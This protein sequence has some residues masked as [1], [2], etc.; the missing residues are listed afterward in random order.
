[1]G[2]AGK[3]NANNTVLKTYLFAVG[4]LGFVSWALQGQIWTENIVRIYT[5]IISETK[6]DRNFLLRNVNNRLYAMDGQGLQHLQI[7]W[8][9]NFKDCFLQEIFI[10]SVEA[11]AEGKNR[12][13]TSISHQ[14]YIEK[15]T[16]FFCTSLG[17]PHP[18]W[19][20]PWSWSL[21]ILNPNFIIQVKLINIYVFTNIAPI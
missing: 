15:M 16:F 10:H 5:S 2:L 3:E 9:A 11:S 7:K 13:N 18:F 14:A 1:M 12:S 17:A 8:K 19:S 20:S 21:P 6:T 4:E